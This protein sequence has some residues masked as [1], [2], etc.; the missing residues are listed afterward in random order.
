MNEKFYELSAAKQQRIINAGLNVFGADDYQ[1]AFADDITAKAGI[2]KGLLFYYLKNK[3]EFYL[4]LFDYCC[5]FFRSRVV[6]DDFI[7]LTIFS[8]RWNM[9]PESNIRLSGNILI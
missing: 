2:V 1:Q 5:E 9:P 6:T 7:R 4:F 8:N 3:K